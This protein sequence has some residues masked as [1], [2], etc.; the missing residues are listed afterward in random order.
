MRC[1][2]LGTVLALLAAGAQAQLVVDAPAASLRA[3]FSETQGATVTIKVQL[4]SLNSS[5]APTL[6]GSAVTVSP[7]IGSDPVLFLDLP[8]NKTAAV[9][10]VSLRATV[11]LPGLVGWQP[12]TATTRFPFSAAVSV[13]AGKKL[14]C[15]YDMPRQ[16]LNFD[17]PTLSVTFPPPG[18]GH[19]RCAPGVLASTIPAFTSPPAPVTPPTLMWTTIASQH[20]TF[21]LTTST[22]VRYGEIA[23]NRFVQQ[24]LAPG[25]YICDNA[26]FTDPA[27]GVDAKVCQIQK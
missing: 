12:I 24:T 23:T 9:S 10:A 16:D 3:P 20:G 17:I 1:A 4:E 6:T 27:P 2:L 22:A 19:L 21:T 7:S 11:T 13:P 26:Q 14:G 15:R 18:Q 8:G 25:S 5:G